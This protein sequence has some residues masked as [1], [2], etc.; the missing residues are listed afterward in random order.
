[1]KKYNHNFLKLILNIL[2]LFIVVFLLFYTF[3]PIFNFINS[4][5]TITPNSFLRSIYLN[6]TDKIGYEFISDK[7]LNKFNYYYNQVNER[8][9]IDTSTYLYSFK[10]GSINYNN[11]LLYFCS[12]SYLFDNSNNSVYVRSN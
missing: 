6:D 7:T 8:I 4:S 2:V 11:N 3:F 5:I 1:M 9:V 10:D 12:L